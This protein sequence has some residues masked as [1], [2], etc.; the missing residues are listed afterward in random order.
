MIWYD[1]RVDS[2]AECGQLN[3]AHIARYEKVPGKKETETNKCQF[4]YRL[5]C[6]GSREG[7]RNTIEERFVEEMSFKSGVWPMYKIPAVAH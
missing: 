1:R 3:L 7:T 6:E 4:F 5:I 2:K